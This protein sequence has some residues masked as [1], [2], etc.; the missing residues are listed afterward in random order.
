[1]IN[2]YNAAVAYTSTAVYA[3]KIKIKQWKS[4]AR[5]CSNYMNRI[6][7]ATCAQLGVRAGSI[8]K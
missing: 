5:A 2:D 4:D 3:Q 8:L 7:H 6:Q 1:L